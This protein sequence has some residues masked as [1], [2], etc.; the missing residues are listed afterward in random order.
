MR[1]LEGGGPDNRD[2]RQESLVPPGAEEE[3]VLKTGFPA[4]VVLE[5]KTGTACFPPKGKE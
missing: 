1:N 4:E 5:V 3:T 2:G